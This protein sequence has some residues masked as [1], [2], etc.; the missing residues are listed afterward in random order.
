M[1]TVLMIGLPLM[2][3]QTGVAYFLISKLVKVPQA[4]QQVEEPKEEEAE[5]EEGPTKLFV[6]EDVIINPAGTSG[7]R[8]LNSTIALEYT[9]P[10]LEQ[11]LTEKEVQIRDI[12]INILA[13]K[14]IPEL[15]GPEDREAL[16]QEIIEK[17][18]AFLKNGTIKRVYFSN[19]I[20][21]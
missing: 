4:V 8:F 12:L 15:D 7:S 2:V 11:E 3:V 21:Q 17:C 19:F 16:K 5:E 13:S 6:I 20:M 1:K 14:S 18:N 10:D 9:S